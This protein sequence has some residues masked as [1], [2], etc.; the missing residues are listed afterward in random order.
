[1]KVRLINGVRVIDRGCSNAP[2]SNAESLDDLTRNAEEN[3]ESPPLH[4][5]T[6]R[7]S[8][9]K[10]NRPTDDSNKCLYC[11]RGFSSPRGLLQHVPHCKVKNLVS[12]DNHREDVLCEGCGRSFTTEKG[13]NIHRGKTKCGHRASPDATCSSSDVE[14][15]VLACQ[16]THHSASPHQQTTSG[17]ERCLNKL[18]KK[19]PILW[20]KMNSNEKWV[21]YQKE[22]LSELCT[23]PMSI[24]DRINDFERVAYGKGQ[25]MFG[26][27][28]KKSYPKN[29]R[30]RQC[31]R[32]K[33][34][35]RDLKKAFRKAD[36]GSDEQKLIGGLEQDTREKLS[37]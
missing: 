1:M 21:N 26:V 36:P 29:R 33:A 19:P 7:K 9:R 13:L 30:Q 16:E 5:E 3:N 15:E 14:T 12:E 6:T 2:R 20:P 11:Q 28:T 4:R 22:V 32:L 10:K 27:Y 24:V 35:M 8:R 17:D 25:E 18:G 37:C 31:E 23:F 34:E